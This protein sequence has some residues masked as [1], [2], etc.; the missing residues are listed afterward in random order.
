MLLDP[1]HS[2]VLHSIA[3]SRRLP[4]LQYVPRLTPARRWLPGPAR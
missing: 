3:P 2:L 1:L 4:L